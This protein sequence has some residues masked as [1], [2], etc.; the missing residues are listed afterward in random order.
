MEKRD[1]GF[2]L[3]ERMSLAELE[4]SRSET[5]R[6]IA[7]TAKKI[8]ACEKQENT[9][10]AKKSVLE[11]SK[12]ETEQRHWKIRECILVHMPLSGALLSLRT[13]HLE[14]KARVKSTDSITEQSELHERARYLLGTLQHTCDHRFVLTWSGYEGSHSMDHDDAYCGNRVCLVCGFSESSKSSTDETYRVLTEDKNRLVK[15]VLTGTDRV[16]N[17]RLEPLRTIDQISAV[18]AHAERDIVSFPEESVSEG[19]KDVT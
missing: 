17:F 4:A 8:V 13:R 16:G 7:A 12:R 5:A 9:L 2:A 10:R 3:I 6:I 11:K 15:R 19:E 1:S 18:F 14:A